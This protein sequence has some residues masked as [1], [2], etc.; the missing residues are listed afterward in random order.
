M[1][2][3]VHCR[4]GARGPEIDV[5]RVGGHDQNPLDLAVLQHPAAPRHPMANGPTAAVRPGGHRRD[6]DHGEP[7]GPRGRPRALGRA[8]SRAY[9][10]PDLLPPLRGPDAAA[11]RPGPRR[12]TS[13]GR[14]AARRRD[15]RARG[16]RRQRP[17]P[18]P[19]PRSFGAV[20]D[21]FPRYEPENTCSPTEKLGAKKLRK[22]LRRT[23][24]SS[25]SSYTV[26]PCTA[27]TAGTRRAGQSTG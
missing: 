10:C 3:A 2:A 6:K 14:R 12:P 27:R 11:H 24:G 9:L 25:I 22:L 8:H 23:Y 4:D 5:V 19:K 1:P 16:R 17:A 18:V 15:A 13:A 21:D 20:A 26:R 7:Q